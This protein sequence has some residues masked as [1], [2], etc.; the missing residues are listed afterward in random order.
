MDNCN[1]RVSLRRSSGDT[2]S[3]GLYLGFSLRLN[4]PYA[5]VFSASEALTYG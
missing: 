1:R 3:S 5:D 4:L 2:F